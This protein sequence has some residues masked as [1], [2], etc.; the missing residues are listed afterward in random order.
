MPT[1]ETQ[2]S[3]AA[4]SDLQVLLGHMAPALDPREFVFA[5]LAADGIAAVLPHAIML[6]REAE[7]VTA[8]VE[9]R[10]ARDLG[11][12]G[13]FVSRMITLHVY[14][15]LDAVGFLATLLPA[16]AEAGMGVNPVSAFHH[17]HLFVPADRA[18]DALAVLKGIVEAGE[19]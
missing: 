1:N 11:I 3:G 7:G 4:V 8:I 9:A 17:D 19:V 13:V 10:T 16:L 6:F 5:T 14:S 15:A 12:E 18:E 2:P